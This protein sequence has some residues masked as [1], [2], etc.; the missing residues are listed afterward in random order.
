[1]LTVLIVDIILLYFPGVSVT[2]IENGQ[3]SASSFVLLEAEQEQIEGFVSLLCILIVLFRR[4]RWE[5][6]A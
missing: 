2:S 1:M 3:R 6:M 4:P 5:L